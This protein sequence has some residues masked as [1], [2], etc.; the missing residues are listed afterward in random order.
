VSLD[1]YAVGNALA[2]K[3]AATTAPSGTMG[4]TT[5]LF[6]DVGVHN[7]PQTPAIVVELPEGEVESESQGDRRIIHDF[8]VYFLWQKAVGDVPRDTDV[9]LQWLGPLLDALESGNQLALGAQSGW[10]V[11]KSR[12]ISYEP[13]NYAVGGDQ[14]HSWHFVVRVWTLDDL[15][16]TP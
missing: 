16:V 4:G 9:M 6:S 2:A 13:G 11:L 15:A 10:S 7:L 5:I 12:D 8:H 14:Y 1:L 3:F